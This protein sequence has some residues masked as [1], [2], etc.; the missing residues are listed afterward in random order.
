MPCSG[1]ACQGDQATAP[2]PSQ[3][4]SSQ[5]S[6]NVTPPDCTAEHKAVKKAKKKLR[7]AE[8]NGDRKA[9]KKAKRKLKKAKR[10]L[11]ACQLGADQRTIS[12]IPG[13]ER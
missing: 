10:K 12:A 11:E 8:R 7:K 3:S 1:D 4:D 9:K 5:G 2:P 13:G 6:G